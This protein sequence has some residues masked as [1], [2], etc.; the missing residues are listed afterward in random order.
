M[1]P[2]CVWRQ[3]PVGRAGHSYHQLTGGVP[4]VMRPWR[5]GQHDDGKNVTDGLGDLVDHGGAGVRR[6]VG[7]IGEIQVID[8][9]ENGTS[10]V[11]RLPSQSRRVP[12]QSIGSS[13]RSA[14]TPSEDLPCRPILSGCPGDCVGHGKQGVC[15]VVWNLG[16]GGALSDVSVAGALPETVGPKS[17]GLSIAPRWNE[18][19]YE[20]KTAFVWERFG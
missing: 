2:N 7:R 15:P 11:Y 19:S 17:R 12:A 13:C 1:Q 10:F 14:G 9:E 6:L 16:L 3:D 18:D 5:M 8:D 4:A 20:L